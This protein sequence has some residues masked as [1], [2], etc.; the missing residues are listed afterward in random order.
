[1]GHQLLLAVEVSVDRAR[2]QTGAPS[3]RLQRRGLVAVG[4]QQ[5]VGRCEQAIAGRDVGRI[6]RV[7]AGLLG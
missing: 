5:L 3:H 4:D 7:D 1:M 6:P 2:G